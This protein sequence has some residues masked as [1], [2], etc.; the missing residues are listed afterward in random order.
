[1]KI[2]YLPIEPYRERYTEL[3]RAWTETQFATE[4]CQVVTVL[5]ES[6]RTE[7]KSGRVLDAHGRSHWSLTQMARLVAM[8]ADGAVEDY[9]RIYFDDMFTPGVVHCY[10]RRLQVQ[11]R[12]TEQIAQAIMRHLEPLGAGVVVR[13]THL[14]M[15]ARGVRSPSVMVTSCLLGDL[16]GDARGEFLSLANG[17]P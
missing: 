13:A 15:A 14:C 8:L 17:H 4:G 16:R 9:D 7:I 3:L 2:I 11:E 12:M 1:M 6:L 5:G 10:A